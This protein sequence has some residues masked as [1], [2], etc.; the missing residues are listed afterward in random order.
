LVGSPLGIVLTG[1]YDHVG[2]GRAETMLNSLPPVGTLVVGV[3]D[4]PETILAH[5]ASRLK[6]KV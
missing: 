4:C 2:I 3:P 6:M 5:I 1:K